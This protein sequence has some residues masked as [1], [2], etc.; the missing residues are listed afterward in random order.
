MRW[1]DGVKGGRVVTDFVS[2]TD[3]APTFLE[4]TGL[5]PPAEMTG[6]SLLP[7]LE[8]GKAGRVEAARDRVLLGRERHTQAQEAPNPGGYPVRALRTDKF[9]YIR[10]FEP[11]RWPAGTPNWQKGFL[12]RAWLG[13][14]DNGPTKDYLWDH[15][16]DADV[17]AKYELCFGKRPGEELYD[18]EKDPHQ[19]KNVAGAAAYGDAKKQLADELTETLKK[20]Q[21]PR[22]VGG[23]DK[24]DKFPYLGSVPRWE[25]P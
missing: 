9:L 12:E 18:L 8:S 22:I 4:A 20:L 14:C 16:E 2:L 10:N 7:V 23:S 11:E 1:K 21:D 5:K 17:K 6:R 15:R 3:I 19:L 25:R 13:D 24:F